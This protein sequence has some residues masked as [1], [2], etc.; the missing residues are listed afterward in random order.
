MNCEKVREQIPELLSGRLDPAARAS[1]VEHLETC[2]G[3]RTEVAELNAVW[4]GMENLNDPA[5]AVPDPAAKTR[6]QEV[7]R[8]YEAGL[9]TAHAAP[10]AK[11]I[12]FPSH[13]AWRAAIAAGLLAVGV[14]VGHYQARPVE[15]Q[16]PEISQLKGQVDSL[17][18]MVALSMLQQQSPSARMRGVTYTEQMAQPDR[19]VVDALLF[20]VR[21]DTNENVRQSAVDALQKFATDPR[22]IPAL[23]DAIPAQQSPFVQISIMDLLVQLRARNTAPDLARLSKD[24]HLDESVRQR[25]ELA[26]Q[27]LEGKR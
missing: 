20:A 4:R 1:V 11:V 3:C 26:V 13:P 15:N 24:T 5:D 8:A 23:V 27:Q 2:G 9:A 14:L 12:P 17:R 18:Q 7:L 19:E 6:F 22:V 25:A 21:N 16:N 10:K